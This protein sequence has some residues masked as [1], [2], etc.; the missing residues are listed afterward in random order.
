MKKHEMISLD[1]ALIIALRIHD[2]GDCSL[3]R[4]VLTGLELRSQI[5][6]LDRMGITRAQF[7]EM[8][9]KPRDVLCDWE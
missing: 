2:R 3:A 1:Q 6:F 9:G 7:D 5:N 8:L 4:A